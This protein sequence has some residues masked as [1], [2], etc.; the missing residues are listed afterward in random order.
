MIDPSRP[1]ADQIAAAVTEI[2]R[3]LHDDYSAAKKPADKAA[4]AEKLLALVPDSSEASERYALLSRGASA[5]DRGRQSGVGIPGR[6]RP[7]REFSP[8]T[9]SSYWPKRPTNWRRREL[10]TAAAKGIRRGHRAAGRTGA[11]RRPVRARPALG[12]RGLGRGPQDQPDRHRQD[13]HT[14]GQGVGRWRETGRQRRRCADAA[15]TEPGRSRKRT[16]RWAST[17]AC[18]PATGLPACRTLPARKIRPCVPLPNWKRPPTHRRARAVKIGDA[19]WDLAEHGGADAGRMRAV[20]ATGIE[21]AVS[22]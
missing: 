4:L 14:L 11:R 12:S 18:T 20:P 8:S 16:R 15:G 1:S 3:V 7:G 13:A 21:Q 19:W 9:A 5:G 22:V 2:Q 10:P 6:R 17:C